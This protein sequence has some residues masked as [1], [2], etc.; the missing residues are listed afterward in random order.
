MDMF[1]LGV[2]WVG[3]KICCKLEPKR[4]QWQQRITYDSTSRIRWKHENWNISTLN[5]QMKYTSKSSYVTNGQSLERCYLK[6]YSPK[7]T[8]PPPKE[9]H[10]PFRKIVKVTREKK[11]N[12]ENNNFL[13][14]WM[15]LDHPPHPW[16]YTHMY[17]IYVC[18]CKLILLDVC[19]GV[20]SVTDD[21]N[22]R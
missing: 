7:S 19:M 16:T 9:K 11:R 18:T 22:G 10:I 8:P 6:F 4:Q 3:S 1:P 20:Q 21:W 12:V 5:C 17:Y 13:K 2:G 15:F 14:T